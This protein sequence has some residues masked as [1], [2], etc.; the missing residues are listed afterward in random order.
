MISTDSGNGIAIVGGPKA[1]ATCPYVDTEESASRQVDPTLRPNWTKNAG[2][3]CLGESGGKFPE[4]PGRG[5]KGAG[6]AKV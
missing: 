2:S 4:L 3:L 5:L 6:V 1:T